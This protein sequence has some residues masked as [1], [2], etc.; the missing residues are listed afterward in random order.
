LFAFLNRSQ[1][2]REKQYAEYREA[3]LQM[4]RESSQITRSSR[5]DEAEEIFRSEPRCRDFKDIDAK[6]RIFNDYLD[7]LDLKLREERKESRTKALGQ[8]HAFLSK[9]L[10]EN[11][12]LDQLTWRSIRDQVEDSPDCLHI[13]RILDENDLHGEFVD[14]SKKRKDVL[15]AEREEK[16]KVE[17]KLRDGFQEVLKE[18]LF[19]PA[20]NLNTFVRWNNILPLVK[21]DE[22]FIA[23][24]GE[25][26][27]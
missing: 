14:W 23:I 19:D 22:R 15:E 4:L 2:E 10:A 12:D 20:N 3:Y 8:F 26:N 21:S 6:K 18:K 11:Q 1:E 27:S 17:Q 13:L 16:R 5:F 7:E 24:L 9:K 25:G